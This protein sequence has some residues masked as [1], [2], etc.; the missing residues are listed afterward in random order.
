MD[1][2]GMT[3]ACVAWLLCALLVCL[4]LDP[5]HCDLCDGPDRV[6]RPP[7]GAF[8]KSSPCAAGLLQQYLLVLRSTGTPGPHGRPK[9]GEYGFPT[10]LAEA[11][12]EC[13]G[14]SVIRVPPPAHSRSRLSLSEPALHCGR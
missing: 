13:S 4:T 6:G 2:S 8:P 11:A 7:Q 1:G 3:R 9:N 12:F 10:Y 5:P 14:S